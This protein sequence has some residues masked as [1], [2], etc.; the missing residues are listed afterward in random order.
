MVSGCNF[1]IK[2]DAP[3]C[4]F[5]GITYANKC[6]IGDVEVEYEGMCKIMHSCTE[7]EKQAEI[8]T[9]EY[10]PVCANDDNTYGN[11][12]QACSTEGVE[13]Y[14]TGECPV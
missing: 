4:G 10:A 9:M 12:C 5:D 14:V 7:E 2:K 8:C 1:C 11:G 6:E 13:A 3:V